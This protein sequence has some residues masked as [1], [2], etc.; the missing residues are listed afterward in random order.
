MK[1]QPK[2]RVNTKVAKVSIAKQII[3]LA[4]FL[5]IGI[6]LT[7]SCVFKESTLEIDGASLTHVDSVQMVDGKL[8]LVGTRLDGIMAAHLTG[9]SGVDQSLGISQQSENYAKLYAPSLTEIAL[10]SA[11]S[12]IITDAHGT[13]TYS[14]NFTLVDGVVTSDKLDSP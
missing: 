4:L 10:N 12:L 3:G 13:T 5:L 6:L 11:I 1:R 7:T 8:V 9:P 14:L 2:A